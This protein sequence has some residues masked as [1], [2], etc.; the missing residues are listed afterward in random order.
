M[1]QKRIVGEKTAD[2]IKNGM[3]LGLRTGSTAYYY[4]KKSW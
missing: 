1:D 3:I 4:D 2:Y